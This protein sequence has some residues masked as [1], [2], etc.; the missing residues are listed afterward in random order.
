[1][2]EHTYRRVVGQHDGHGNTKHTL[3][4]HNVAYGVVHVVW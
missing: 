2:Y 4:H 3:A 1:M